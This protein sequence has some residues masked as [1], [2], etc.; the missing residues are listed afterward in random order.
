MHIVDY[1]QKDLKPVPLDTPIS[2][3]KKIFSQVQ[4]SH[5]PVIDNNRLVGLISE[6]DVLTV[7]EE[8]KKLADF[9]YLLES[10]FAKEEDDWI[11]LLHIFARNE[12]N[13]LP[14]LDKNNNY[15][16][17][18]DLSDVLLFFSDTP[19]LNEE[20][21]VLVV[22]KDNTHYS[23]SEIS[24]IIET[25]SGK[26]L[27]VMVSAKNQNNTQITLKVKSENINEII[28][29]F[30]RYE[31]HIVSKHSD[32]FYLEELKNRSNYLQKYLNV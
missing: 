12:S 30:R 7:E 29:S 14:L 23:F 18:F 28:Q 5:L 19:F 15:I 24:Q 11:N 25:N 2:S 31:Y 8:S 32:D 16:G 17:Y 13:L 26:L 20:G 6:S 1:I 10:F 22:E 4:F 3:V 9:N 21:I 27:G